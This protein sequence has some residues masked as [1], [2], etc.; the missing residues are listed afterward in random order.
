MR[1]PCCYAAVATAILLAGCSG[2]PPQSQTRDAAAS[3]KE[4]EELLLRPREEKVQLLALK[5][6][7]PPEKI[8]AVVRTYLTNHDYM[9]LML[10]RG[11]SAENNSQPLRSKSIQETIAH[12]EREQ[13]I[14]SD[15]L[16]SV[17]IDYQIWD[18][19][20]YAR[21]RAEE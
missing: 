8:N 11:N 12:L 13:G 20:D 18:Y 9:Y 14:P 16:A 6:K 5:Y 10:Q 4:L 2:Q 17:I 1:H 19:V 3:Q 21:G 15:T 7:I